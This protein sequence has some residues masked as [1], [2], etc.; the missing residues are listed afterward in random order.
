[1]IFFLGLRLIKRGTHTHTDADTQDEGDVM[2]EAAVHGGIK[3][4]QIAFVFLAWQAWLGLEL[5]RLNSSA[6]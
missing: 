1:M 2:L 4:H 5:E 3:K 6:P